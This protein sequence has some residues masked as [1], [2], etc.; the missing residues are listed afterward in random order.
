MPYYEWR[1]QTLILNL[2]IQPQASGDGVVGPHGDRLK[3]RITA[4]PVDGKANRHLIRLLAKTF[5]VARSQITLISG[6]TGPDKRISITQPT[7]LPPFI[8]PPLPPKQPL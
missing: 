7:Q 1:Q 3:V 6:E 5:G 2:H 8:A 4:P